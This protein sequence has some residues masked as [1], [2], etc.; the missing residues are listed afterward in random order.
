MY[1]HAMTNEDNLGDTHK[2]HEAAVSTLK[3]LEN[4]TVRGKGCKLVQKETSR[5]QGSTQFILT[6]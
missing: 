4:C 3:C 2:I 6:G 1:M 5:K